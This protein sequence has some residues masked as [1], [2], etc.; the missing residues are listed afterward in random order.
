MH[1]VQRVRRRRRLPDLPRHPGRRRDRQGGRTDGADLRRHQPRGHLRPALLRD[2]GAAEGVPR[3][4]GLPRRPARHRGGD[5]GGPLQRAEDHRQADRAAAGLDRRPRRR[6]RRGD[7]DDARR[8]DHPDRRLRPQGRALDRARG[9]RVR[10]DERGQALVRRE[11]E[12]GAD[13]G[14]ARRR[15]R[16]HGHLRRPLRPRD[17]RGRVAEQDERRRDRLRDGQPDARGDAR[18]GRARTCGSWP[19]AAPTTRTRSTTCSP[20]PASSA[21]PSTP[22][23]RRSPRR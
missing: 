12:P 17:H 19:P 11:L 18:G 3:H 23:P 4:P 20:S 21:A 16:G 7:E 8:G 13:P 2:R 9:L 5:D 10:R 15:N 1:A 14:S 22:A 6:R